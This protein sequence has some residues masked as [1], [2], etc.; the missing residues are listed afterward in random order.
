MGEV[1]CELL[2]SN[3][4][5]KAVQNLYCFRPVKIWQQFFFFFFFF[6]FKER[7][8]LKLTHKRITTKVVLPASKGKG[9]IQGEVK[10][11]KEGESYDDKLLKSPKSE[12]I[13]SGTRGSRCILVA[14]MS[15][16]S[17]QGLQVR[18]ICWFYW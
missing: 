2:R 8:G 15:L 17:C 5:L 9:A 13:E 12:G 10:M 7:L 16:L 6:F 4:F 3:Y 1:L 11:C 18:E 14:T